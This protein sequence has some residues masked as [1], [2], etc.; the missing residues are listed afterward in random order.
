MIK[1]LSEN[2][3]SFLLRQDVIQKEEKEIY[4]Y[5]FE[6]IISIAISII[7]ILVTAITL[8]CMIETIGLVFGFMIIRSVAGGYHAK[9]HFRCQLSSYMVYLINI[10]MLCA[11]DRYL[12]SLLILKLSILAVL[13][14]FAFA[15]IDHPNKPFSEEEF[16]IFKKKSRQFVV[17]LTVITFIGSLI[18]ERYQILFLSIVFGVLTAA[19]SILTVIIKKRGVLQ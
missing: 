16:I 15:P 6:Y 13:I 9:T 10:L 8:N 18:F 17:A 7:S 12:N 3:A 4:V 11:I 19:I 2:I 5:G 1:R 14:I